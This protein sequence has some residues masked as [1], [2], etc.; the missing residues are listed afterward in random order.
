MASSALAA[1]MTSKPA[2][3]IVS[4][5]QPQQEFV[6]YDQ[7]HRAKRVITIQSSARAKRVEDVLFRSLPVFASTRSGWTGA[8]G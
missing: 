4:A 2:L 5:I 6:F 3:S 8:R 7:D 1:W